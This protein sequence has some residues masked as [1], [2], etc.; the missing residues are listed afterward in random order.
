[1]E[2]RLQRF[3]E[4]SSDSGV[5]ALITMFVRYLFSFT[6]TV[7]VSTSRCAVAD[8]ED[9]GHGHWNFVFVGLLGFTMYAPGSQV[10]RYIALSL[11]SYNKGWGSRRGRKLNIKHYIK[12]SS[13]SGIFQHLRV[14][15]YDN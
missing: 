13:R 11:D 15:C 4:S 7:F 14:N 3:A 12:C 8:A 9:Y 6:Y 1:M 10:Q 5:L 2:V